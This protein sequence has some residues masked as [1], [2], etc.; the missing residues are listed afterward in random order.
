MAF[1]LA[2]PAHLVDINGVAGLDRLAVDGDGI[3]DRRLRAPRRLPPAGGRRAARGAACRR[4]CATSRIIR[5]ARAA[6]SAAASRMPIRH[7]NGAWSRR[8][9]TP[10]W[11]RSSTRGARTIA[12]R[13]LLPRHHDDGA[14][15]G[16]TA[17]RGAAAAPAGR[18]ALRL[19]RVQPPRRRLRDRDGAGD[20]IGIED[21]SHR[22]AAHRPSA[23][24][25]RSRAGSPRPSGARGARAR[26]RAVFRGSRRGRR[27]RGRSARG[28]RN[29]RATTAATWCAPSRARALRDRPRHERDARDHADHQRPQL[30]RARRAAPHAGRCDPRRLR[31]DRHAYRLRARRLRRLHGAARRRA[32]AL[33]PDVRGAG[34][35]AAQ[36]APSRGWRTARSCIRCSG[37]HRRITGCNAASARR[38]S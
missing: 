17:R 6:P 18:H 31:P 21:G 38:A 10:R 14:G 28:C 22:R 27:R 15:R 29:Q 13:R 1:R 2:R 12:A 34:A 7:P 35:R 5:S 16:R 9:S 20:A 23:A 4:W 36:S 25:R 32:G 24:P 30:R 19:L 11:W 3:C 37:L 33:L 8:R 26:A